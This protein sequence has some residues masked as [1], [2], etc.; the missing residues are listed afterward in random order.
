MPSV[1]AGK[2]SA[3]RGRQKTLILGTPS[4]KQKLFLT[5]RHLHLCYGGARG[6]G[7]SW[8]VR[9]KAVL[10]CTKWRGIKVRIVRVSYPELEK[11]HIRPL[12]QQLK[13]ISQYNEQKKRF[14]F[15]NGSTIEFAY[16]ASDKDL[17][18]LQGAEFDVIMLDEATQLSEYQIRT[19]QACLRGVNDFPKRMIYTCNPGGQGHAYIKRVF[20]DRQ[21]TN[22]ER[23]EDYTFIQALPQDNDALMKAQPGYIRQLE[24]LPP[25]IRDAWLYGRWD[26]YEGMAFEE[27]R[28]DPEHYIDRKWTHVIE[29]FAPPPEWRIY[30]SYDFGYSKPFSCAWWAVDY[31]GVLYRIMELYGCQTD[32]VSGQRLPDEGLKW[33]V[34]RQFAEIQRIEREHPW[35]AGKRIDGVADPAIWSAEGSGISIAEV[36]TQ[37]GVFFEPGDHNR[38]AGWMQVHYRL[39][40]DADGRPRMYFF[41]NCRDIIRTMPQMMYDPNR[42]EDIDS[43][44]E[45]HAMDEC[46]YMCMARPVK[47]VQAEE[48]EV[49]VPDPLDMLG[50]SG[51]GRYYL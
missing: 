50:G 47:P 38:I 12:R 17:D 23:P 26:I 21:F 19:F 37:Y 32:P 46:R 11:N 41:R 14:S 16:C 6:G 36:A 31:D 20:V 8:A 25:K 2:R 5:D 22:D 33:S 48:P 34:D 18:R 30:R 49:F 3:G 1:A 42:P 27:F 43:K 51:R 24:A 28:D 10:M 13:G 45:D 44:L 15:R 39:Q 7:K 35:L 40:F 29:P 4:A 9:T